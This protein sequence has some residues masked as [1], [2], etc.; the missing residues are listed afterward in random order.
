VSESNR[1]LIEQDLELE[2]TK[3]PLPGEGMDR[4]SM[5][6]YLI[7]SWK[8]SE[9]KWVNA[10]LEEDRLYAL[11]TYEHERL[12]DIDHAREYEATALFDLKT[13]TWMKRS[14]LGER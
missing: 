7:C 8:I 13:Q 6:R 10:T 5:H 11:R 1:T 3:Y 14:W 9:D 2:S 12:F 4:G